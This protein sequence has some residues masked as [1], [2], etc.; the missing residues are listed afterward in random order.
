[1]ETE[2]A[3][4]AGFFEGE[5]SIF[6]KRGKIHA[7]YV[8]MSLGQKCEERVV[9]FQ[10]ALGTGHVLGPYMEG[11]YWVWKATDKRSVRRAMN[12]MWPYFGPTIK[13]RLREVL[14]SGQ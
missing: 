11:T 1:M 2:V 3:W 14:D 4:A 8:H 13:A 12:L 7:R 9:R 5:G 6:P 10:A